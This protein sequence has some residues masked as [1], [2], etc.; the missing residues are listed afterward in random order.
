MLPLPLHKL[1][2]SQEYLQ[3]VAHG[4]EGL[5]CRVNAGYDELVTMQISRQA[6]LEPLLPKT[7]RRFAGL[8]PG[9]AGEG[10]PS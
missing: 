8:V 10:L 5:E 9:L 6:L 7:D 3:C 1:P 2:G 4:S